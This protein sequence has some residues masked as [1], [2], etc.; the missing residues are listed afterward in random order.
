M[1]YCLATGNYKGRRKERNVKSVRCIRILGHLHVPAGSLEPLHIRLA[2]SDW[3][4]VVRRAPKNADGAICNVGVR[5]VCGRAIRIERN[6]RSELDS[7]SVPHLVEAFEAR[8]QSS[9]ATAREAHK[10]DVLRIDAR[11]FGQNVK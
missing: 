9:L 7:R 8:V 10:H 3:I 5:Y 6:V 1:P 11:V 4:V 2:K